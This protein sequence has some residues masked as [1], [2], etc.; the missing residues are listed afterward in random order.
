MG[1]ETSSKAT[2]RRRFCL[3]KKTKFPAQPIY[4]SRVEA[5]QAAGPTALARPLPLTAEP[6]T[7]SLSL[8]A[9][10]D[11]PIGALSLSLARAA[12]L[13]FPLADRLAPPGHALRMTLPPPLEPSRSCSRALLTPRTREPLSPL[14]TLAVAPRMLAASANLRFFPFPPVATGE[15]KEEGEGKEGGEEVA[16]SQAGARGRRTALCTVSRAPTSTTP[17]PETEKTCQAATLL[18]PAFFKPKVSPSSSPRHYSAPAG[19]RELAL[20]HRRRRT[21][22]PLSGRRAAL[23]EPQ[24]PLCGLAVAASRFGRRAASWR[25]PALAHALVR[26]ALARTRERTHTHA[27]GNNRARERGER[28]LA[29]VRPCL[30]GTSP[31]AWQA[32]AR[33]WPHGRWPHGIAAL[34]QLIP[35]P[36]LVLGQAPLGHRPAQAGFGPKA[37]PSLR[38]RTDR[39]AHQLQGPLLTSSPGGPCADTYTK[40]RSGA[41]AGGALTEEDH[42]TEEDDYP[43]RSELKVCV[44]AKAAGNPSRRSTLKPA[45]GGDVKMVI[46]YRAS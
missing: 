39:G 25:L 44:E 5:Q 40:L 6:R 42:F 36:R 35:R 32:Y 11:P 15:G 1:T 22:S 20:V 18:H 21:P 14:Q 13:S 9:T 31:S 45:C 2:K 28:T 17:P 16:W 33:P 4:L 37:E 29:G 26:D 7:P 19:R 27:H 34:P 46:Y 10:L 3:A 41:A 8:S 24:P 12:A 23:Q 38:C 43:T 30:C